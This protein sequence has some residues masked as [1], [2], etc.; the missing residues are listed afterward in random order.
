MPIT[1][2][3]EEVKLPRFPKREVTLWL[4]SVADTHHFTVNEL[5]YCFVTDAKI[6]AVNNEYL[7]HDYFTDVITFD[8]TENAKISG[9]VYIS[10]DTVISNADKY[11]VKSSQELLRVMVHALLHLCGYGDKSADE[12]LQMVK[13]EDAAL[14]LLSAGLIT[15]VDNNSLSI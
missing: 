6:L 14:S 8:Y 4:R 7:Q 11:H 9:D 1:Y 13:Y 5:N 3:A 12:H 10:I 15:F 2:Q